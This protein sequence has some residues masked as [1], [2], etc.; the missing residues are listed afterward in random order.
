MLHLIALPRNQIRNIVK[1]YNSEKNIGEENAVLNKITKELECLNLHRTPYNIITI[2]KVSEKY[3]DD[4]PVNRTKMIE[5]ILFVLFDLDEIPRYKTMPDLKDCEYV[6][7]RYCEIMLKSEIY[8]F[9][10]DEFILELKNS[11]RKNILTWT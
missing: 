11:A 5:M 1:Q 4:S 9:K 2:L 8:T 3:F 6:L 10:K 7:G